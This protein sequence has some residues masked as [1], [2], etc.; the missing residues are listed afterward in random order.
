MVTT[1]QRSTD[2]SLDCAAKPI[3]VES[4]IVTYQ[5]AF[6]W[7]AGMLLLALVVFVVKV[8]YEAHRKHKI[9]T[10]TRVVGGLMLALSAV[11]LSLLFILR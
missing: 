1:S 7:I 3:S 2:S 9:G 4:A 11:A 5:S 8:V 10:M 6:P